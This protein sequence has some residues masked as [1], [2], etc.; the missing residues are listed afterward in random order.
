MGTNGEDKPY[1]EINEL[2]KKYYK[3]DKELNDEEFFKNLSRKLDSLFHRE[4]Y[5]DKIQDNEGNFLSDEKR[6]WLGLEEY[7]KNDVSSLKHKAITSHLLACKECRKNYN[8]LSDKKKL[9][10]DSVY[11][12]SYTV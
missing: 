8:D 11:R 10:L 5:S 3:P 6:Y 9:N 12:I 1:D 2:L 4:V 7:L